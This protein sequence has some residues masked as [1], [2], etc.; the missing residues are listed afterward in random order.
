[1]G[2]PDVGATPHDSGGVPPAASVRRG[3][4]WAN[5]LNRTR[6][7]FGYETGQARVETPIAFQA[8]IVT[9]RLTSAP[10]SSGEK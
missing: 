6:T 2:R 10:S 1:M 9:I 5:V 3:T 4:R 8:L 7:D